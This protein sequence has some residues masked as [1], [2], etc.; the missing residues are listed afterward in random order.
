[1]P[2]RQRPWPSMCLVAEYTTTSAPSASGLCQIGVANTL[3]TISRAPACMRDLGDRGDVEHVERRIG[4]AF[5]ETALGV[6]PHRALPLVE[7]EAIDQRGRDAVARQQILHHV[8]AGAEHRLGRHHVIAGFQRR[9]N[10]RRHRGHAGRGGAAGLGAFELDHAPL[11]HRD[12]RIGIARIDVAGV[13]A[14]EA[15]LALLGGVVDIALG[16]EQR[17]GGFA[18]L[19]AQG[20]GMDQ[21]GFGAVAGGGRRGDLV[22]S[23]M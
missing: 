18:E 11:E 17:L 2:P 10:G 15:R 7:I 21:P 3:S 20:S 4:R 8:A 5:E 13:F 6:R 12:R 23:D 22:D 16:E 19:R 9:Q 1:M 14:L